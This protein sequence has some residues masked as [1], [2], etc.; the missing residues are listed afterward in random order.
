MRA[1]PIMITITVAALF[2]AGACNQRGK[3]PAKKKAAP[4]AMPDGTVKVTSEPSGAAVFLRGNH[5]LGKTPL[6]LKR[7]DATGLRLMLVKES[8]QRETFFVMVEGG[9]NKVEHHKLSPEQ[10][11]IL[12]RAGPFRGG[13]VKIDGKF[14]GRVPSRPDVEAGV[15]HLV[16]VVMDNFHTYTERVTVKSGMLVTVNAIMI[17]STQKAPKLAWLRLET[18]APAMVYLDGTLIGSTPIAKIPV[19]AKKHVLKVASKALRREKTVSFS[20]KVGETK[21]LKVNLKSP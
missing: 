7:P 12:V 8:Y 11:K 21:K 14:V 18:D 10:G 6:T 15:E 16:E 1:N 9:K 20:L 19:P 5:R 3:Q 2:A 13:Q 17:P 4:R